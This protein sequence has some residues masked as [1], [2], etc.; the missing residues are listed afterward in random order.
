MIRETK[1]TETVEKNHSCRRRIAL[2]LASLL[3]VAVCV[4]IRYYWG[5]KP[6]NADAPARAENRSPRNAAPRAPSSSAERSPSAEPRVGPA[7][8]EVVAVVN[9]RRITRGDLARECIFHYGED[10]L[11]SMVNK[12]LIAD[13]C[14]RRGISVTRDEVDAEIERMAKRFGIPKDQ[15]FKML[16]RERNV[17]AD[18]YADDII[19]PTLALRKLA[20]D[21]LKISRDE[22]ARE[23][24]T[25][26][27]EAVRARLIAVRDLEKAKKL[28]AQAA[29]NP[30]DFGNLAKHHSEDAAS[31]SVKGV[32]HPIRKHGSYKEIEEAAFNMADG[33]ISPVIHAGGQY[34]ILK[35]DGLIPARRISFERV[36]PQLE[37][38][39]RDRRMRGVAQDVFKQLQDAAKESHGIENVWNN[40]A[41]RKRMP[42]VAALVNGAQIS[43]DELAAECIARHGR[44][45]LEGM[46]S[47]EIL[48]Q[49]CERQGVAVTEGDMDA[50]IARAALAGVLPKPDGSPDVEAWLELVQKNQGVSLEVYRRDSVWPT[51]ALKKLVGDKMQITEEDLRKGFEANFGPRVR[52]LAIVLDNLRRAQQVFE[53]ARQNNTAEY[54]GDLAGEYSIEPGSQA[55]RGEI[56]PIKR[57]GGQPR[58]EEEAFSLQ[59]GEI[60]GI[61]QIAD[62]FIILRC[63]GFTEPIN[64]KYNEVRDE[65]YRDLRE[66]K[67]R[68]AMA[69]RF[70]A[71]REA[72]QV[73]N[74]LTGESHAPSPLRPPAPT[75]GRQMPTK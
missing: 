14:R 64:V 13:E 73:D 20:G 54:F 51:A 35:R 50:E 59:P 72:A 38:I 71:L 6:A 52:C 25:R 47:R 46:I 65:I 11:E 74:Y 44:E 39:I 2:I 45:T 30:D 56:P 21:R 9:N 57:H 16:E 33:E 1:R 75:A 41:K 26:Y 8:P 49:A 3:L 60:S 24:E 62:K 23:F 48:E 40:P 17:T 61:I 63:E 37:E 66:K 5:A 28:R 15:W 34:V 27:G 32:I 43:M 22:V 70:E 68:L 55:L 53:M 42:G 67:H 18:Q 7:V 19:W 31:A 69:E 12:R 10:V 36:A 4:A 58:L 29:A